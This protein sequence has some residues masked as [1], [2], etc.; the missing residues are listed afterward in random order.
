M[1]IGI[2]GA[3]GKLGAATIEELGARGGGHQIVA[4]SRSPEKAGGSV[5]ARKG[6]YDQP[7]TLADAYAGLDRLVLIPSADLRPGVRGA[8][9][10]SAIDAAVKAGVQHIFLLSAAGTREATVPALGESY[11]TGE[12]YLIRTAPHWT[13]L[14]MNYYT[15]SMIDEIMMSQ[16]QGMLA[17]L[18]KDRVAYV[19]R[20]DVAAATAGA[21]LGEGHAGAIYNLT[22]P[23][24][25][26][27]QDIAAI[28]SDALGKPIAFAAIS[29]DQLRGGLGQAG[30][31]DFV[32]DAIVDIKK[33]FVEGYFDVLTHDVERLSGRA[34]VSFRDV[35]AA[36]KP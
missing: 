27:G 31:P 10:K 29:E 18:G 20:N 36:T 30:L 7:D 21:V 1:K 16:G 6:D 4:I 32:L 28:A 15:Q 22:G 34:P 12:Q 9:F 25:L 24:A 33:T 35:L 19:S 17:G 11:W 23:E 3:S 2:S 13:I 8:Q 14:R 26:T 5:E